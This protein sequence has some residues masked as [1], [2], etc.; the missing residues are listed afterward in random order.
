[1]KMAKKQIVEIDIKP[2]GVMDLIMM[3]K[4]SQHILHRKIGEH[5]RKKKILTEGEFNMLQILSHREMMERK[6]KRY[7]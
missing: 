4:D 7:G 2:T 3:I 1:M 6:K 5:F